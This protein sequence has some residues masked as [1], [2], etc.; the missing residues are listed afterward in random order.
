[1]VAGDYREVEDLFVVLTPLFMCFMAILG[2]SG[3]GKRNKGLLSAFIWSQ[4]LFMLLWSAAIVYKFVLEMEDNLVAN[5]YWA[6]PCFVVGNTY[7]LTTVVL[8]RRIRADIA[9]GNIPSFA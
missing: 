1:M 9:T 3:T 8:A 4:V 2:T 5:L 7:I 6:V